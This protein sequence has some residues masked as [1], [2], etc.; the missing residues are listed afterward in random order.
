MLQQV[1]HIFT[2]GLQRVSWY[3]SL[4]SKNEMF[5]TPMQLH[6][7]PLM[8]TNG[9]GHVWVPIQISR[10]VSLKKTWL[11]KMFCNEMMFIPTVNDL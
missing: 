3:V 8:I 11:Y 4:L 6:Y 5:N 9:Q 7:C 10:I 1:I 2:T